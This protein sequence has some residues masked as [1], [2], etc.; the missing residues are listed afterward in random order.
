M[1]DLL[2]LC[3]NG[4]RCGKGKV[5]VCPNHAP[6]RIID[7]GG[8]GIEPIDLCDEHFDLAM[9]AGLVTEPYLGYEWITRKEPPNE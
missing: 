1:S 6:H 5:P 8:S 2:R 4:R 9:R 3:D 7:I